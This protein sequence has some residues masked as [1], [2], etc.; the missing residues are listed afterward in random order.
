MIINAKFILWNLQ[1]AN[2]SAKSAKHLTVKSVIMVGHLTTT[3]AY[4][5]MG[6]WTDLSFKVQVSKGFP[7][8]D[9][10]VSNW[11]SHNL[12]GKLLLGKENDFT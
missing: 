11:S 2:I 8:V 4:D 12:E 6:I 7:G 3:I 9:V 5:V 10:D 1:S